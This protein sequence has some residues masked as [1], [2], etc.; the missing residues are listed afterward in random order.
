MCFKHRGSR[1]MNTIR[2]FRLIRSI[3]VGIAMLFIPLICEA[4]GLSPTTVLTHAMQYDDQTIQVKGVVEDFEIKVS[5]RGNTYETF[6]LCEG[7]TCINVF[8]W[9]KQ[10]HND[11]HTTTQ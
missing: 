9:G 5:H 4:A 1:F 10:S 11:G 7:T 3:F 8:A 6:K 2:L